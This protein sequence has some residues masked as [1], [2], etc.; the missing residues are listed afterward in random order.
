MLFKHPQSSSQTNSQALTYYI[1]TSKNKY[2]Q[3]VQEYN[4]INKTTNNLT[5]FKTSYQS[6][7]EKK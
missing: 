6:N 7:L 3:D 2:S 1:Y 5:K 4:N